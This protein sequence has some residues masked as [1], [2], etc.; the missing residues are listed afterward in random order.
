MDDDM[1]NLLTAMVERHPSLAP[2]HWPPDDLDRLIEDFGTVAA[3]SLRSGA[4]FDC[5]V[6]NMLGLALRNARWLRKIR[7]RYERG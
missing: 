4:L 3:R 7:G 1:D 5:L 6:A 2:A